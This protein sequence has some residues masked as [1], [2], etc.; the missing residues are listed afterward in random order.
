MSPIGDLTVNE[1]LLQAA[2]T[3]SHLATV[4]GHEVGHYLARHHR[5]AFL[6]DGLIMA[7]QLPLA[8]VIVPGYFLVKLGLQVEQVVLPFGMF[9]ASPISIGILLGNLKSQQREREA[10]EI[11]LYL[12][13]A[14]VYDIN[15]APQMMQE[16]GNFEEQLLAELKMLQPKATFS[17][18]P[19]AHPSISMTI[20]QSICLMRC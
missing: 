20:A 8:P 18:A 9:L 13:A 16:N 15:V 19:T 7:L 5:E 10:D 17:L 2:P 14:A 6:V 1:N 12:M 4:I 3:D 11:G